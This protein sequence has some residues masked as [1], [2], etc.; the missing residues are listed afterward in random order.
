[1]SSVGSCTGRAPSNVS[2]G[3]SWGKDP[4]A[5]VLAA[6]ELVGPCRFAEFATRDYPD[7]GIFVGD[8][9]GEANPNAW[10]QVAA[11]AAVQTGNTM[12]IFQSLFTE[13]CKD[14]H[15]IQVGKELVY[16]YGGQRVIQAVTNSPRALEGNR[17]S[18]V[19]MNEVHHWLMNNN[20][21]EMGKAVRRNVAKSKGG[22]ARTLSITNAYQPGEGSVGQQRRETYMR[23]MESGRTPKGLGVMYDSVEAPKTARL[24]LPAHPA[25]EGEEPTPASEDEIRAYIG[26]VVDAVRGDAFYL[27]VDRLVAEIMDEETSTEESR[28]FYYNQ[29]IADENLWVDPDAVRA[30]ISPQAQDAS[31]AKVDPLRDRWIVGPDDPVVMFFDGSKSMD[32]SALVGCRVSDGHVF[33]IGVWERPPGARGNKW[34]APRPEISLRVQ[35]AM[36]RFNVIAFWGDP[37]HAQDDDMSSR[38]WDGSFDDW[39][40][41]FREK[42]RLWSVNTGRTQHSIM[43]DMTSPE[44]SKQFVDAAQQFVEEIERRNEIEE[45]DPEF[46]IC[47]HPVL[48]SHLRNATES[49]TK[50]GTSLSKTTRSSR[51]KIDAAVCA[52]GARMLRRFVLNANLD[53]EEPRKSGAFWSY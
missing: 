48:V 5:A 1:M 10:V 16:A 6:I 25:P 18:F 40:R 39:H 51:R 33:L 17:P 24:M 21:V 32:A 49:P 43:W 41:M 53:A 44:R 8:P 30:A 7:K 46:T 11:V 52:V 27:D 3:G 47:G 34:T 12:K 31:T 23:A 13:E 29:V 19:I 50:W 38:Y 14:K 35:E 37:S 36:E 9:I 45:F 20:G 15:L 26:A 2:R 42:L 4:F 28:R 22:A